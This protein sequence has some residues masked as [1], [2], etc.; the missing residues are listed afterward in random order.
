MERREVCSIAVYFAVFEIGV[1]FIGVGGGDVVCCSP[2]GAA[3]GF[4]GGMLEIVSI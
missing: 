4:Q 1:D 3:V 2:Y